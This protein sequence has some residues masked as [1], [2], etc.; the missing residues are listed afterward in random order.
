M[1]QRNSVVTHYK[2]PLYTLEKKHSL[3][4]GMVQN[5]NHTSPVKLDDFKN[6]QSGQLA[7]NTKIVLIKIQRH[8]TEDERRVSFHLSTCCS[9][10]KKKM[11]R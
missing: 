1:T 5:V 2:T 7:T 3:V 8:A 6:E 4:C 11:K 9:G 10:K